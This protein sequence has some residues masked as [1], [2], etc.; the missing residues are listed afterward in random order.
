MKHYFKSY[1][2][3]FYI[4]SNQSEGN[5]SIYICKHTPVSKRPI[6]PFSGIMGRFCDPDNIV[7]LL[8]CIAK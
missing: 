5:R 6:T 7:I 8:S 2:S 4:S 3:T 1:C